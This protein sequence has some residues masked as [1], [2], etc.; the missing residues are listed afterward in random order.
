MITG[1]A[2][3]KVPVEVIL[4][5]SAAAA[6]CIGMGLL[7]SLPTQS[8]S[9]PG[10]YGSEV[11]TGLALGLANPP[12]YF[13]LVA[14]SIPEK[15]I[16]VGT[17]ALNMV[18]TLGGCVAVAIC[19]AIHRGYLNDRLSDVLNPEQVTMVLSSS[20]LIA[21]LPENVRDRI[22]IVFG[23]SYNRQFQVMIAFAG[24]NVFVAI[25]LAVVR[26]RSGVFGITPERK[27]GNEFMEA[28]GERS[29]EKEDELVL[30]K[31][32][33]IE[34][35][36]QTTGMKLDAISTVKLEISDGIAR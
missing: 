10:L 35:A 33:V 28:A 31:T 36:L 16:A 18:R 5:C 22:G 34:S 19:S 11:I 14:T 27:E 2:A 15:D 7:S 24:L 8:H 29:R 30:K 21:Q 23:N 26:R 12:S 25:I 1:W 3:K 13:A 4:I 9:W 6:V 17:G 20:S 32:S